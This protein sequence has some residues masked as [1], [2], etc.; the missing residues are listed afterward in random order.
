MRQVMSVIGV[1]KTDGE[2]AVDGETRW[3][4]ADQIGRAAIGEDQE[5][6]QLFEIL[7][8][9]HMKRAKLEAHEE[10]FG[11]WLGANNVAR[12]FERVDGR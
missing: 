11:S 1:W 12:G 9:L 4:R 2:K 8:L 3:L 6:E 7:R 10:Y 5:R